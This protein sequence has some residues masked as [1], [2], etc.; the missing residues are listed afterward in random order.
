[1]RELLVVRHAI[2]RDRLQ[3]MGQGMNDADRPL[4]AE[5]RREMVLATNQD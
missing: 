1:M 3:S 4:T 2:A 5:G